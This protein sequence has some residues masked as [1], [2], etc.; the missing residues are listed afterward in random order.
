MDNLV[1]YAK[2]FNEMRDVA[3][4]LDENLNVVECNN[5]MQQW[6]GYSKEEVCKLNLRDLRA[7]NTRA[8]INAQLKQVKEQNGGSWE[9]IHIR[10]DGSTFPVEITCTPILM[11]K[12]K[13]YYHVVRD[14]SQR[15]EFEAKLLASEERY[16]QIVDLS[17]D[18]LYIHR[19]GKILFM[20]QSGL[21]MFGATKPEQIVGQ[22][23]WKFYPPERHGIVRARNQ[24][25]EQ[26][27][28]IAPL[29]E[30][31]MVRLDGSLI[32][33]EAIARIIQYEGK[34]AF[35]VILRDIT[36]KKQSNKFLDMQFAVAR[37]L[38]EATSSIE[39]LNNV[40]RI[41]SNNTNY[42]SGAI[43]T[44]GPKDNLLHC[45]AALNNNTSKNKRDPK[46]GI[47]A[48]A[49]QAD[50]TLWYDDVQAEFPQEFA[51]EHKY[52]AIIVPIETEDKNIGFIELF[53]EQPQIKDSVMLDT[54][55]AIG[56]QLGA[57][58]KG[59]NVE[60]ELTFL[61]K[62]N[63][64]TGLPNRRF[65]E[66]I[67]NYKINFAKGSEQ[68]LA[69]VLFS[70]NNLNVIHDGLGHAAVDLLLS[71]IAQRFEKLVGGKD[72]VGSL[73]ADEFA[74]ILM[75]IENVSDVTEFITRLNKVLGVGFEIQGQQ[76]NISTNF[77]VAL[78]PND[79]TDAQALIR[80][81]NAALTIAKDS[82]IGA[83][84]F[85][86]NEMSARAAK[87]LSMEH[88]LR[89]ALDKQEFLLY[90][91]PIVDAKSRLVTGFE[92]LLR[93]LHNGILIPP[94]DFIPIAE[95]SELIV[96]IGEWIISSAVQQSKIWNSSCAHPICLSVNISPIQFK[97]P[98]LIDYLTKTITNINLDPAFLKIEV[99]E[100][101]LMEDVQ[102][103]IK[104]LSRIKDMG[105]K[106][107]I[108]DFGT[109]YSSLNYLRHL[110]IDYLK[111]DQSFVRN[112]LTNNND[113]MIIRAVVDLAQHLGYKVIA[114]GVET[115]QQLDFL[116]TL[117]DLEIQ[118]YF[119]GRPMYETEATAMLANPRFLW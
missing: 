38:I 87:K 6:Y 101:A 40:I 88:D 49:L 86:T 16:H 59:K 55:L 117:G 115:Q 80:S 100:S 69:L 41:I 10:K 95:S 98:G 111:I 114:E 92:C 119:F 2:F 1:D 35:Y 47:A 118:G 31:I 8:E 9:T 72:N 54:L 22:S 75:T 113:A 33:V 104:S 68:A 32:H 64:V 13:H 21:R 15:K 14:I 84:Q 3:F 76:I 107:S 34:D 29:I 39:A 97:S 81:V 7:P 116:N 26:T 17:P 37:Q 82:G 83:V 94:G 108:D 28:Q 50:T 70:V 48:V 60:K 85:C 71:Q 58:L 79:G 91:Q 18:A 27:R 105:V 63:A 20:N 106:V 42:E 61:S 52:K 51:L 4:I 62:H 93:W 73:R 99:T 89:E 110:P 90:F 45:M 11:G 103:S 43:W 19:N 44:I 67:L 23:L 96:P 5:L 46:L 36:E 12:R 109:G 66:E 25:M 102:S 77:G 65:F 24:L 78:Y 56:T 53:S 74:A 112:M 57:Y 30:H